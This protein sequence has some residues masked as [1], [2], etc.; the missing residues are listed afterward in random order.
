[1][2]GSSGTSPFSSLPSS[3]GSY[4]RSPLPRGTG[5]GGAA[6]HW[7]CPAPGTAAHWCG[8]R[9]RCGQPP[10]ATGGSSALRVHGGAPSA[11]FASCHLPGEARPSLSCLLLLL[12]FPLCSSSNLCCRLTDS[13]HLYKRSQV[14][15]LNLHSYLS[16]YYSLL[17]ISI[18]LFASLHWEH[19][20]NFDSQS[21]SSFSWQYTL[22]PR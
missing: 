11:P 13:F 10:R 4:P 16:I 9:R 15:T 22:F 12:R 3:H 18:Y 14:L 2:A 6:A 8:V 19:L 5:A 20:C 1:M 21:C 7:P 17:H